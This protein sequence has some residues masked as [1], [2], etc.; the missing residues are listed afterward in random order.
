MVIRYIDPSQAADAA[1]TVGEGADL[2]DGVRYMTPWDA[3]AASSP[4]D[5]FAFRNGYFHDRRTDGVN[6]EF[7]ARHITRAGST[8]RTYGS[9]ANGKARLDGFIWLRAADWASATYSA[10]KHTINLFTGAT[11]AQEA[12]ALFTGCRNDGLTIADRAL[13]TERRRADTAGQISDGS[14]RWSG[15][16]IWF[17]TTSAGTTTLTVY[18]GSAG[19]SPFDLYGVIAVIAPSQT[20]GTPLFANNVR[21][22]AGVTV[23]DLDVWGCYNGF[24]SMSQITGSTTSLD[25]VDC[26]VRAWT[27]FAMGFESNTAGIFVDGLTITRPIIDIN[28][29]TDACA[30]LTSA[31]IKHN[32]EG[33]SIG[34]RCR[35]VTL[36]GSGGLGTSN[37]SADLVPTII[38]VNGGS[39]GAISIAS[40][41][42][43]EERVQSVTMT[44]MVAAFPEGSSDGRLLGTN[45][46]DGLTIT[47]FFGIRGVTRCQLEGTNFVI[48]DSYIGQCRPSRLISGATE[49]NYLLTL[50]MSSSNV[51]DPASIRIYNSIFDFR[52]NGTWTTQMAAICVSQQDNGIPNLL[53]ASAWSMDCCIVLVDDAVH[54]YR[55]CYQTLGN[56]SMAQNFNNNRSASPSGTHTE[57]SVFNGFMSSTTAGTLT[58]LASQFTGTVA[59]NHKTTSALAF[60]GPNRPLTMPGS[61]ASDRH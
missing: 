37:V 39:H 61:V 16:G 28:T 34:L 50:Q 17:S 21:N 57:L 43:G 41:G 24:T 36:T 53:L 19:V 59:R 25:I 29:D 52:K 1:F 4:G 47:R 38:N 8:I 2:G 18:T 26:G 46:L 11:A 40:G 60:T 56:T 7:L 9:T 5:V 49:D 27:N 22:C 51:V 58:T 42:V 20:H 48:K 23:Q 15:G 55:L 6:A 13:G 10:G 31:D 30:Q 44:D 35:N 54:A 32:M 33:I 3:Y 14:D 12:L 45:C